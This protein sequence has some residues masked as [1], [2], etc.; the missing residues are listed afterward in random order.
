MQTIYIKG[1][2]EPV[3]FPD[4]TRH[5]IKMSSECQSFIKA[6]LEKDPADRLGT[7]S[8]LD[9]ILK[10]P[11]FVNIDFVKLR[12][13]KLEAPF[14]PKLSKDKLDV[15]CFDSQFTNEEAVN[16]VIPKSKLQQIKKNQDQF[17]DFS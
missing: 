13:K 15:S 7:K 16:S 12:E 2:A 4:P 14:L 8:G 17:N 6:L 11:W 9:D 5:K 1:Q 3:Y 10:H